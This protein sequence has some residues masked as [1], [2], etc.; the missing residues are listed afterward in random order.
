MVLSTVGKAASLLLAA[1]IGQRFQRTT[2]AWVY[3]PSAEQIAA[4]VRELY[5]DAS[6]WPTPWLDGFLGGHFQTVWYGLNPLQ[7]TFDH[8]ED[9]WTTRDG[10][11]L[12]IAWPEA[13]STLPQ[14]API[15]LVLPGLC[16][17]RPNPD[18]NLKVCS[19]R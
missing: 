8:M 3:A 14:S 1:D 13:P 2:P 15:V 10:G 9:V 6:Y 12:G 11:T 4:V 5:G 16:A 18:L 19:R 7:P 17:P